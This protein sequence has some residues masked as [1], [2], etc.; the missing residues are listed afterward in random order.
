MLKSRSKTVA[1]ILVPPRSNPSQYR[2][3]ESDFIHTPSIVRISR[4]RRIQ[5]SLAAFPGNVAPFVWSRSRPGQ[6]KIERA[7]TL[8]RAFG[9]HAAT[10][11]LHNMFN[12]GQPEAC[13]AEFTAPRFVHAIETLEDVG[14]MFRPDA[15]AIIG[16]GGLDHA[17]F[18][19]GKDGHVSAAVGVLDRVVEKVE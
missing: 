10:V 16:N 5:R 6:C 2:F 13:P 17:I 7:A 12:D 14:Q 8:G 9:P 15:G 4:R 3:F 1:I 18:L 19:G 11:R